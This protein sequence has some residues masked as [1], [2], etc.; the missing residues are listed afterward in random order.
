M[1]PNESEEQT[2]GVSASSE[3]GGGGDGSYDDQREFLVSRVVSLLLFF[4]SQSRLCSVSSQLPSLTPIILLFGF[5]SSLLPSAIGPPPSFQTRPLGLLALS[6]ALS[7]ANDE[8]D[9]LRSVV[10]DVTS[11]VHAQ[12]QD[13]FVQAQLRH[14]QQKQQ[15]QGRVGGDGHDDA[16][17]GGSGLSDREIDELSGSEARELLKVSSRIV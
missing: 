7:A 10:K 17:V 9:A 11:L 12:A 15:R 4:V 3:G 13:A 8:V 14:Q 16:G 2:E 6:Q 5:S 1:D